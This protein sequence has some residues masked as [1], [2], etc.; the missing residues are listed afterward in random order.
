MYGAVAGHNAVFSTRPFP[1]VNWTFAV[2][3]ALPA[4]AKVPKAQLPSW[5]DLLGFPIGVAV[6]HNT[7]YAPNDNG[8]LY[9]LAAQS[10]H[11]RWSFNAH[12]ELMSTPVV[13]TIG[14]RQLV[15][16]GS[17]N[18][19]FSYSQAVRFAVLGAT[20]VRGT[21]LSA[22]DAVNSATGALVW[23][24]PT[25]GESMP[26]PVVVGTTLVAAGGGGDVYGLNV[27]TGRLRWKTPIGSFVSMSSLD[28]SGTTVVFGGTHPS[29]M[30]AIDAVT[31][32]LLWQQRPAGVFSSSMGD[33]TP[34]VSGGVEV[35][36]IEVGP[37]VGGH[38]GS[39]EVAVTASTG[40]P[41]W[42][43]MLG[44]GP[45]PPRNKDG[46]AVIVGGIVYTASPVTSAMQALRLSDGAL[47]W[48]RAL[49][50]TMKSPP[51]VVGNR[52]LIP[53]ASGTITVLNAQT[54]AVV[55]V[56][57]STHGG[58]GPQGA[59]VVGKTVFVGTNTGWLQAVALRTV[60]GG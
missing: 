12:N 55:H 37:R 53:A 42:T 36:Q 1:A 51:A 21:G 26:T 6:A 31:G 25:P 47:L 59:V 54:G 5:R 39:E 27:A 33:G 2:P 15:I 11:V 50:S 38:V 41:L 58:F 46:N 24:F 60:L 49:P 32:K 28:V 43:R 44:S 17:G 14:G 19:D 10:G 20:V 52:V 13:V 34:A 16:V 7:V 45:V 23:S 35:T 57:H 18:A 3:G 40:A 8:E 30:D 22:I 48:R 29:R 4:G 9:A 56:W